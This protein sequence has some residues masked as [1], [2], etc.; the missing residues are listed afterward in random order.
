MAL[1]LIKVAFTSA[2]MKTGSAYVAGRQMGTQLTLAGAANANGGYG[3]L[4]RV[5]V[6]DETS[7]T[8]LQLGLWIANKSVTP[9]ADDV[10]TA[11]SDADSEVMEITPSDVLLGP[12]QP[13]VNNAIMAWTGAVPYKCDAAGSSLFLNLQAL[14]AR[15]AAFTAATDLK[16]FVVLDVQS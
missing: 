10:A 2:G 9:V 14:T 1:G 6:V 3:Y 11:F 12:I 13:L 4:R 16:G 8:S 7:V 15:S 5:V